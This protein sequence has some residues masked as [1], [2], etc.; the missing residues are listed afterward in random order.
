MRELQRVL[1]PDGT[2]HIHG[3]AADRRTSGPLSLPGPAAAVQY[4]PAVEEVVDEVARA[5]FVDVA[6]EKLSS[7]AYFVVDGVAFREL[8]VAARN[9]AAPARPPAKRYI[10]V[11]WLRSSTTTGRSSE[12]ASLR[13]STRT[14]GSGSRMAP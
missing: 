6:I 5:G 3:L 12:R 11:R 10:S 4:V 9:P 7:N 13:L 2:L 8:R 14:P 1:R